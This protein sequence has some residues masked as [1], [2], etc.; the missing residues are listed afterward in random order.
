MCK[1]SRKRLLVLALLCFWLLNT[2]SRFTLVKDLWKP[3][4]N[5]IYEAKRLQ[6]LVP[7][8]ARLYSN[9]LEYVDL[10]TIPYEKWNPSVIQQIENSSH[11]DCWVLTSPGELELEGCI[12]E[13]T[14]NDGYYQIYHV[15][16]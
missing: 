15:K 7:E 10:F 13:T 16:K 1:L 12:V 11:V 3:Y 14:Y 6:Q 8:D 9:L 5:D 4:C 2:S